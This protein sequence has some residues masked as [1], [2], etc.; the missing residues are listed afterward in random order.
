MEPI[1]QS[2]EF[3]GEVNHACVNFIHITLQSLFELEIVSHKA[4]YVNKTHW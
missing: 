4:S 3:N 1:N 2:D